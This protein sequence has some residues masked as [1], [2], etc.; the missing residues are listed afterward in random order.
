M[1]CQY[2][3]KNNGRSGCS[4]CLCSSPYIRHL[5]FLP[6]ETVLILLRLEK[7]PASGDFQQLLSMTLILDYCSRFWEQCAAI[8]DLLSDVWLQSFFKKNVR[9]TKLFVSIAWIL[10][11]V[12]IEPYF[13]CVQHSG[14][15][16]VSVII[17]HYPVYLYV[18]ELQS[19][20]QLIVLSAWQN[21]SILHLAW[22]LPTLISIWIGQVWL[23]ERSWKRFLR[24]FE[25]EQRCAESCRA[26]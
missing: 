10:Q 9:C 23:K 11:L 25:I 20:K 7:V 6:F 2:L 22:I 24:S 8:Y 13:S 5:S 14:H 12:C 21:P 15:P 4:E 19:L 1:T 26:S 18:L 17:L 3:D 16:A